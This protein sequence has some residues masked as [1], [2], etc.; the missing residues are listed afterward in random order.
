MSHRPDGT[1]WIRDYLHSAE[2]KRLGVDKL[3]PEAA[4]VMGRHVA[5]N[6]SKRIEEFTENEQAQFKEKLTEAAARL[7]GQTL[8]RVETVT[9]DPRITHITER[10]T[11]AV[12]TPDWLPHVLLRLG[13][14]SEVTANPLTA[15][16]WFEEHHDITK[17]EDAHLERTAQ[18]GGGK[19][20]SMLNESPAEVQAF[21]RK[22][23]HTVK[24]ANQNRKIIRYAVLAQCNPRQRQYIKSNGGKIVAHVGCRAND[25]PSG[26]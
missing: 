1:E 7:R 6:L 3:R 11:N 9:R 2:A 12:R 23:L 4:L 5:N 19:Y 26:C 15:N 20:R 17:G 22:L 21:A 18:L 10:V 24:M 16:G 25:P 13:I 14:Y 8:R